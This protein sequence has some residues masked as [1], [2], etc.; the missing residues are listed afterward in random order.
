[1]SDNVTE[2][3]RF[4]HINC[5]VI[6]G[7]PALGKVVTTHVKKY[8]IFSR[9]FDITNQLLTRRLD[10]AI[11]WVKLYAVDHAIHFAITYPIYP[12]DNVFRPLHNWAQINDTMTRL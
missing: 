3:K 9:V 12:L 11:H 10:S 7:F 4:Y 6:Q 1:M 8:D 5:N 2:V